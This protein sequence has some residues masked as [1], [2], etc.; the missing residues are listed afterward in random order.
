MAVIAALTTCTVGGL[1]PHARQGGMGVRDASAGSK[2]DGTGFE[3]EQIGHTQVALAGGVGAGLLCRGGVD[4]G[5]PWGFEGTDAPRDNC[6]RGFGYSVILGD[7]LRKPACHLSA[8]HAYQLY[9]CWCIH[10]ILVSRHPLG[11]WQRSSCVARY[12]RRSRRDAKSN[13]TGH[14]GT[15]VS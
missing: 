13:T 12:G 2:L 7:D 8:W 5:A 4:D 6:F 11:R 15:G 3:K 1:I 14:S 10:K 9:S